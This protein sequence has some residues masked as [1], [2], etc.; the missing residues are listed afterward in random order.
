MW[1]LYLIG[2]WGNLAIQKGFYH[3][4]NGIHRLTE[5]FVKS[6]VKYYNPN[7]APSFDDFTNGLLPFM[8]DIF[9]VEKDKSGKDLLKALGAERG[10]KFLGRGSKGS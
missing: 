3:V 5:N 1:Q 6:K 9:K 4:Y 10:T 8:S 7:K 2:A